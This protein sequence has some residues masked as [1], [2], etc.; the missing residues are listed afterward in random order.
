MFSLSQEK[1]E[2]L[3]LEAIIESEKS[4]PE[5]ERIHPKVGAVLT[6]SKGNILV[7]SHRGED[8]N[9]G[10]CE[11]TLLREA[12]HNQID[13]NDKILF[14]T[15]EPCTSRGRGKIPCAQR[16][17]DAGIPRIFVGMLDPNQIIC[18][19]GETYLRMHAIVERFPD[20]LVKKIEAINS[21]FIDIY[22]T[23]LLPQTSLYVSKQ[24]NDLMTEYLQGR[25]LKIHKIPADWDLV[26]DDI[27]NYCQCNCSEGKE[28]NDLVLAARNEAYD[29][30][31]CDYTYDND[32]RGLSE[33]WKKE[34][35]EIIKI[36]NIE[37]IELYSIINVGSGNGLE[38]LALFSTV[39]Q[40][41]LIDIGKKSLKYALTLVPHAQIAQSSAE[42]LIEVQNGSFDIYVSLRTYQ[43]SF[44]DITKSIR[45][46]YRVLKPYGVVILSI[47][48][49]FVGE[50]GELI[51]GLVVPNTQFVDKNRPFELTERIRRHLSLMGFT[52]IGIRSGVSEIYIY[53][54]KP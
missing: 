43:S 51:P 2:E 22:R 21:D 50:N 12:V 10:H 4:V 37:N 9:G 46:V 5:D 54:R 33:N 42:N 16:I 29:N 6:D 49:A 53:G 23:E 25:G 14:V 48:N 28:T 24:I 8:G 13:L 32:A 41:V 17:V 35:A 45:E 44:F 38:A 26:I 30:K 34:F 20:K 36:L 19:R 7:R 1:V 52:S 18:G 11:Y 47:A 40:L 15:L 31:Y 39:K 27:I 3:M